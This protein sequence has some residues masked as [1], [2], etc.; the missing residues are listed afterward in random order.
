ME[1]T[2]WECALDWRPSIWIVDL[3]GLVDLCVL[4]CHH[5]GHTVGVCLRLAA[6]YVDCEQ[7]S[8]NG[9]CWRCSMP[10]TQLAPSGFVTLFVRWR[11]FISLSGFSFAEGRLNHTSSS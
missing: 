1:L 8:A 6:Q 4:D 10:R 5:V 3:C 7:E 11:G 2:M 9:W